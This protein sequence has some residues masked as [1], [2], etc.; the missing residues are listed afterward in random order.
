[1]SY[2]PGLVGIRS[3][4]EFALRNVLLD[5]MISFYD[6]GF[7]DKGG[8]NNI[9]IP[10]SGMYG[11][12]KHILRPVNDPNYS[13]NQA[14][15]SYRKNWAWES[16]VSTATQPIQISGIYVNNSFRPLTYNSGVAHYAGSGY[17]IDYSN[18]RV[19]FDTAIP[20]TSTVS[21]NY[22]HKWIS[23]DR[24]EGVPFFRQIQQNS[25]RIDSNFLTSSGDWI[26]VGQTRIQLPAV[27]VEA[28]PKR[29]M[30]PYQ[31]GGGQWAYS[32][33]VF[34]V[35]GDRDAIVSDI[36]DAI[37]YQNDRVIQLFDSNTISKS[38]AY[39]IDIVGN[40]VDKKYTYPYLLNNYPYQTCRIYNTAINDITQI[41]YSFYIGTARCSTE[42]RLAGV[43]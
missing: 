14:W 7:L 19:I 4:Q 39:P 21:L 43:T 36:L 13:P 20:A 27:L 28:V 41:S 38:G 35:L 16:G 30:K 9:S 2:N 6:W 22:A 12:D 37:S 5:N 31:L 11:G 32:D 1:M 15:Q 40:L 42:V 17:R 8:F 29:T 34:Y 23:V 3:T 24:A 18:G 10:S 25:F 33:F 26:Q